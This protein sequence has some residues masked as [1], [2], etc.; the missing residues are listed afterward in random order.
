MLRRIRELE[1]ENKVLREAA[2][3]LSQANLKLGGTSPK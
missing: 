2:A 1:Q 3:Y